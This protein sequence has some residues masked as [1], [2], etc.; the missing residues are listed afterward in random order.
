VIRKLVPLSVI[1]LLTVVALAG[2]GSDDTSSAPSGMPTGAN[3]P[4]APGPGTSP[5]PGVRTPGTATPAPARTGADQTAA[6][7][8]AKA[9][10]ASAATPVTV[11]IQGVTLSFLKF[12]FVDSSGQ[13]RVCQMPLDESN[14]SHTPAEWT[15]TFELYSP[16]VE[17]KV[18]KTAKKKVKTSG[19]VNGFPFISPP[20]PEGQH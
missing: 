10:I 2:C 19:R 15:S 4:V 3:P 11:V 9:P 8:F 7:P 18:A 12:K 14:A 6:V 13:T 5:G 1:I 20:P 16:Q 17:Q